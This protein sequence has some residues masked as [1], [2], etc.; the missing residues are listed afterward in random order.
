VEQQDLIK[1]AGQL[2]EQISDLKIPRHVIVSCISTIA[3]DHI[4]KDDNA[5]DDLFGSFW[6]AMQ[7]LDEDTGY[8]FGEDY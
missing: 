8:V 2:A 3:R 7:L 4:P 1:Y 6:F 5:G